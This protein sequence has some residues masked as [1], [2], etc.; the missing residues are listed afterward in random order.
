ML[1]KAGNSVRRYIIDCHLRPSESQGI[2]RGDQ[3]ECKSP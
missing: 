3:Q 2:P 1:K